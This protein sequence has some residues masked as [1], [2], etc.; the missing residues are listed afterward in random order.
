MTSTSGYRYLRDGVWLF[1]CVGQEG[2]V[3]IRRGSMHLDADF[4]DEEGERL[5]STSASRLPRARA[6]AEFAAAHAA[7]LFPPISEEE[8][9]RPAPQH[10]SIGAEELRCWRCDTRVRAMAARMPATIGRPR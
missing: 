8:E 10:G 3:R 1:A 6:L 9:R 7:G 4:A 5:V 2:F